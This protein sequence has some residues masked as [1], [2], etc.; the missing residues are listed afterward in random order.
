MRRAFLNW[1]GRCLTASLCCAA[2]LSP[3]AIADNQPA[4]A[5]T[6]VRVTPAIKGL[7]RGGLKYLASKQ[8]I[9]GSW[10]LKEGRMGHPVAI[11]G[12]ALLAFM[13]A[14]NLPHEGD[15]AKNVASGMQF[16]LESAQPDGLFR[17]TS[18]SQYMYNHGIATIALAELYGESNAP[19]L[20]PKLERAINVILKA[21][22]P[23]GGWRYTPAPRDA[24]ISVTVLQVVALRAAQDAGLSIPQD[25]IDKAIAYVVSCYHEDNG[26]FSYQPAGAPG[27][28]RTA[29]AI[30]SL[31]V[32]GKYDDPR[33]KAGSDY[34]V[35]NLTSGKDRS[36]WSYG[37]Y[38]AAPAQYMIGGNTWQDWYTQISQNITK[39]AQR[40]GD[41]VYWDKAADPSTPGAVFTTAAF[42]H[43]LAMPYHL[44]PLYQR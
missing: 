12:Y 43:V 14:G 21:Q 6:V 39:T 32:L 7:I 8:N 41:M 36:H 40:E 23:A 9:D 20:R 15:Y 3:S 34:L 25:A 2:F 30:Y 35:K 24:D 16:L 18:G 42:V 31:Q 38:Y 1:R 10:S 44:M 37:N 27:F 19:T 17:G 28:A 11:T 22:N 33:V 5:E 13:A 26:G 29:A 4:P